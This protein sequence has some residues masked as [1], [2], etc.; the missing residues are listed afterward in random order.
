M[1]NQLKP[2]EIGYDDDKIIFYLASISIAQED[3]LNEGF[4]GISDFDIEKYQKEFSLCKTAL[5]EFSDKLPVK[6]VK[7]NDSCVIATLH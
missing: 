2:I 1:K 3:E 6:L 7:K 5:G 4:N